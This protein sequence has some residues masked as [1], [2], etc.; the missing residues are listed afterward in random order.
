LMPH[1][2]QQVFGSS[3]VQP[4]F[5][6]ELGQ[7]FL[8]M[9][10]LLGLSLWDMAHAV[11]GDPTAIANLEAGAIGSL[12]PWPELARLVDQ[13]ATLTGVDPQPILAR[14][15]KAMDS[16]PTAAVPYGGAGM[17]PQAAPPYRPMHQPA[18]MPPQPQ[19]RPAPPISQPAQYI[20]QERAPSPSTHGHGLQ[21]QQGRGQPPPTAP[22]R[23]QTAPTAARSPARAPKVPVGQVLAAIVR[24]AAIGRGLRSIGQGMR[25]AMQRRGA[26]GLVVLLAVPAVMAVAGRLVPGVLY[27]AISPLPDVIGAPL[28]GGLDSMVSVLA[29]YRD[30]LTWIDV[31]DP[32]IRKADRLPDR[33]R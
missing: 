15:L 30:G 26:V 18:M 5:D 23:L 7:I 3:F 22:A 11:G 2:P 17:Q 33:S 1:Q 25:R 10:T 21:S 13:Y 20:P 31:G 4:Q 19:P 28:R 32:R 12:P 27:G 8:R 29:P 14:L 9:R 24:P 16:G 6:A